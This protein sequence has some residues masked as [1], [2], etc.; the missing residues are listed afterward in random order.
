MISPCHIACLSS[1]SNLEEVG[2]GP[3]QLERTNSQERHLNLV[4]MEVVHQGLETE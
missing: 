4:I 3:P 1:R 2:L